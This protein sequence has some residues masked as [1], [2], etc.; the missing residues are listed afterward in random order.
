MKRPGST[1]GLI[2]WTVETCFLS[3]ASAMATIEAIPRETIKVAPPIILKL[4]PRH[5]DPI[6]AMRNT[7]FI[8]CRINCMMFELR[9]EMKTER[10]IL[11]I[12]KLRTEQN[13]HPLIRNHMLATINVNAKGQEQKLTARFLDVNNGSPV[14][15]WES[16]KL[17]R[18]NTHLSNPSVFTFYILQFLQTLICKSWNQFC[19]DN[20]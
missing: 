6:T 11:V 4:K 14:L 12:V 2:P 10:R 1:C 13:Q 15:N 7:P 20:K 19:S 5:F 18:T 8:S 16:K 17:K 3:L 9:P